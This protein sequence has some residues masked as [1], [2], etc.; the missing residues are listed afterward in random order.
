MHILYVLLIGLVIGLVA[1]FFT[2]GPTPQGV[3][4]TIVLGIVGS[5]AATY[6]GQALGIYA[7]GQAAGFVGSVIGAIAL[8]VVAR[9]FSGRR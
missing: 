9:L 4:V 1:R 2:P 5:V 7:P 8:I 6:G 3:L